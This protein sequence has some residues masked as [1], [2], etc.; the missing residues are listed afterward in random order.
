MKIRSI[1]YN[2]GQ[3]A[4]NI[5][6]NK[7]F[8]LAS[9]ATMS[10]CIFIFGVF[11]SIVLNF[12]YILRNVETNVGITVFFNEDVDQAGID[13]IGSEI[14]SQTDM[15]KEMRYVSAD[16]AWASFSAKY[17]SGNE[18]AAEGWRNNNDNPLANSAHFEVY[19]N[20]I[21][22]Q[23]KLV[24]YIQGLDGVRQVNQSEQA[25]TTL[26]TMNRLIATI[27]IIIILVLLVVSAFLINNTVTVG[28]NVRKEEIA[29]QKLIG[30]TNAFVRLPFILEGILIG[31]IGAAIPLIIIYFVYN[32][33]V[34]YILSRFSVLSSFMNGLLPVNSV[35]RILLPVGLILGVGIALIGSLAAIH[36]HL[37]V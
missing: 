20:N 21:E 22:Q 28:I 3:G 5:V 16:E 11:F 27:S 18:E 15:V 1:F 34:S 33:A 8:S 25:S 14:S 12:S 35:Y 6:R 30:A 32:K 29:I 37:K 7:M 13:R 17:F 4:K 19:P 31:L 23:D 10:A 2:A 36:K 26:S 24:S 9:I